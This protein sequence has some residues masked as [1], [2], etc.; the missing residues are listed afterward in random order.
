MGAS[1]LN[2]KLNIVGKNIKK[3]RIEEKLSQNDICCKMSLM[4]IT[5]YKA[6]IY[7]I[8]HCKRTIKDFELYGFSK[9]LNVSFKQLF[10]GVEKEFE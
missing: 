3:Y 2:N 7:A 6:D 4:G 1:K 8:E 10:E 9:I 5:M